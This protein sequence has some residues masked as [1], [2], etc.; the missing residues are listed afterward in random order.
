MD[1]PKFSSGHAIS[2]E[3]QT[4]FNMVFD[5]LPATKEDL[6]EKIKAKQY[7]AIDARRLIWH[8]KRQALLYTGDNHLIQRV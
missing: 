2:P 5:M 4:L 6:I 1:L 7:S 8:M 3:E